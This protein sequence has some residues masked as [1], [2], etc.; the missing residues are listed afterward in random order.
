MRLRACDTVFLLDLPVE[1][2]LAAAE[3]RVG[4]PREDMPWTETEFD[5]EFKQWILDFPQNELPVIYEQIG[6]FGAEKRITIFRSRD[7]IQEYFRLEK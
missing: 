2:C 1:E 6:R 4:K 5:A 7:E 3:S